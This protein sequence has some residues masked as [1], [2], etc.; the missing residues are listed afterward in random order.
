LNNPHELLSLTTVAPQNGLM[1]IYL[2]NESAL[3]LNVFFDELTITHTE[4]PIIQEDHYYPYGLTMRG[5]GKQGSN[6]FKYNGFE[7]QDELHLG[8]Y[9]YQARYY[10]PALGRFI[11]IDPAA[12]LMR[13]H[14]PYN[15]AFDNPIR[16]T[17]PD[18]M[19]PNEGGKDE[20]DKE[21]RRDI[22]FEYDVVRTNV[23]IGYSDGNRSNEGGEDNSYRA[24]SNIEGFGDIAGTRKR[25]ETR[26]DPG[27]RYVNQYGKT[28][29]TVD[30]FAERFGG[31]TFDQIMLGNQSFLGVKFPNRLADS[32]FGFIWDPLQNDKQIDMIHFLVVGKKGVMMGAVNEL[33]QLIQGVLGDKHAMNSAFHPQDL[34]SNRL[35]V[36][37]FQK[38]QELIEQNPTKL[39]NYIEQFLKN[40]TRNRYK[41]VLD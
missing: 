33:K 18:G 3:D 6:P 2:T 35:G 39:A 17:D 8:L 16:F 1:Y 26:R 12:E 36:E 29:R 21:V 23:A 41:S 24:F 27:K 9:D 28:P 11:N 40:P 22:N 38:Y 4:S 31:M 34:Y 14:S 10:D 37:F 19:M 32:R 5:I 7:E 25:S 30:D 15:Y 20:E 13:R